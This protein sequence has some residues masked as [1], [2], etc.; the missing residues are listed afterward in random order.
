MKLWGNSDKTRKTQKV[1]VAANPTVFY[2]TLFQ[3]LEWHKSSFSR[4]RV[5]WF[6]L[7][8]IINYSFAGFK[9]LWLNEKSQIRN[10]EQKLA[11]KIKQEKVLLA[12]GFRKTLLQHYKWAW[13]FL[14]FSS[15]VFGLVSM[16]P[17]FFLAFIGLRLWGC[18]WMKRLQISC[19]PETFECNLLNKF[20]FKFK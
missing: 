13:P 2:A 20:R 19:L 9:C 10:S 6:I 18:H 16:F 14:P 4:I 12:R 8:N 1:R 11:K 7:H 5:I 17:S 3:K 15:S